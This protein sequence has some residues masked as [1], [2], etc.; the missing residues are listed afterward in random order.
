[1]FKFCF[2][3]PC[4]TVMWSG[5]DV[6]SIAPAK[7]AKQNKKSRITPGPHLVLLLGLGKS[8]IKWISH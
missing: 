2:D 1:M 7:K 5:C 6:S 8:R 3:C 4:G